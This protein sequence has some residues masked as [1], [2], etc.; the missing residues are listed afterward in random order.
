MA[1]S[2][3][4]GILFATGVILV[5]VPCFYMVVED[6]WSLF[7]FLRDEDPQEPDESAEPVSGR[8]ASS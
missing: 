5:V 2:L 3:G 6:V 4:F 1:I 7:R 8:L